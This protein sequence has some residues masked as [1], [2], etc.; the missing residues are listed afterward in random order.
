MDAKFEMLPSYRLAYVRQTGPYGAGNVSAMEALKDWAMGKNLLTESAV[1]FGIPQDNPQ[2]TSPEQCRYDACIVIAEDDL[3]DDAV[4]ESELNG[5]DYAVFTIKH[6]AE[7]IQNAW[8]SIFPAVHSMGFQVDD[9]PVLER[10]T[11]ILL[12]ENDCELCVPV[13]PI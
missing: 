3:V 5:G 6:T 4:R 13:K 8:A 7:A 1:V 9:K 11:G 2:T 12:T 10:Y